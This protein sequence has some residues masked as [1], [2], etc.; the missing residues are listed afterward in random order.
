MA[1]TQRL[2]AIVTAFLSFATGTPGSR[3]GLVGVIA[4]ANHASVG[5]QSAS[6]GTTIYDGDLLSTDAEGTLE[7]LIGQAVLHLAGRSSLVLHG[8]GGKAGASRFDAELL[9]GTAGLSVPS[10]SFGEIVACSARVRSMPQTRGSVRV[11]ILGPRELWVYAQRGAAE[12]SYRGETE[13]VP[14]GKAVRVLLNAE[15]DGQSGAATKKATK[16]SKMILVLA[17]AAGAAVAAVVAVKLTG[18]QTAVESPDH[19]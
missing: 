13:I 19:P 11:E 7:L 4:Q 16:R 12:I 9:S 5:S 8:S 17:T 2:L 15:E 10:A 14:A 3:P 18:R 6:E 1:G